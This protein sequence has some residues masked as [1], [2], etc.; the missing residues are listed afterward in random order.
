MRRAGLAS[1]AALALLAS[2]LPAAGAEPARLRIAVRYPEKLAKGPLDGRLLLLVSTDPSAEP[3]FQVRDADARR[4]SRCSGST[5]SGWKPGEAGGIRRERAGLS[6][7][8]PPRREART[9]PRAGAAPPLRDVPPRRRPRGQAADGPR[10]GPAVE[11]RAWQPAERPARAGRRSRRRTKRSPSSSTRRSPRSS[12]RQD[13]KF[14]KHIKIQSERLTKFWGRPMYLGAV[15]LLPWGFDEHP[16]ARFPLAVFH[17]HF[18][19]TADDFRETPPDP[20]LKCEYSERFHLDCYNRDRAG[21]RPP[22]LQGLDRRPASRASWSSRSST[23]T[24]TTT[25]RTR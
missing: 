7:G 24:R 1:I 2:T 13:T 12:R 14:V 9:L 22:A 16:D 19:Y 5:S 21:V 11:P 20:N 17:G 23:R 6:G 8:E 3:R 4:A 10:R 18:P 15:V 25:T